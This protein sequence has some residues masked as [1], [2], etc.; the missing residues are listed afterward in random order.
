[1]STYR[2][3][4]NL[5]IISLSDS[6]GDY[7][8]DINTGLFYG[9]K[10]SPI[11]TVPRKR[12]V[13]RLFPCW[14]DHSSN[15]VHLVGLMLN[16]TAGTT[17]FPRW[18]DALQGADKLDALGVKGLGLGDESYAYIGNNLKA[19]N[20]W[21]ADHE[22][23]RFDLYTFKCWNEFEKLRAAVG[24]IGDEFT[25][26][27]YSELTAFGRKSFS[28]D[29]LRVCAYYLTKGKVWEYHS[30]HC[31]QLQ[32][33]IDYCRKMGK[34]PQKTNNFMREYVETKK[35]YELYKTKFDTELMRK[36]YAKHSAAWEFEYGDYKVVIPT[37]PKDIIDE[38]RNMCHCVGGYV[39]RVVDGREYICF[40]RH[41]DTPDKCYITC[42]VYDDGRI[43]QYFLA[44]D[45]YISTVEDK[46]FRIAFANHLAKVWGE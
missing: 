2:K 7:S 23:E 29:E 46:E 10:G 41:K 44:H 33:Y 19:F 45:R 27:M 15:L 37:T 35:D 32:N 16:N 6:N 38:G 4:K 14:N 31:G 40:I 13:E 26:E 28:A 12:E 18:V 21:R 39:D 30:H 25:A 24:N 20:K 5:I 8:L 1:M 11:K 42:E 34:I 3:E 22:G 36:S 43:G 17:E 9:L